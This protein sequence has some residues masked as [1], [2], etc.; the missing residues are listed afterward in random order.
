MLGEIRQGLDCRVRAKR[1]YP[2]PDLVTGFGRE[3]GKQSPVGGCDPCARDWGCS[4]AALPHCSPCHTLLCRNTQGCP[5]TAL[6][7]ISIKGRE[8]RE[9]AGDGGG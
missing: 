2:A 6:S 9:E 5:S 7:L 3:G 4:G 8:I 1:K